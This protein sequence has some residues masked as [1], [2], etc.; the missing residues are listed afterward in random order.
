MTN[1]LSNL[2]QK[3]GASGMGELASLR[4]AGAGA[5]ELANLQN[6]GA[7]GGE[8]ANLQQTTPNAMNSLTALQQQYSA[9]ADELSRIKQS[10][11][12]AQ[13]PSQQ[14]PNALNRLMQQYGV[15]T[16]GVAPYSGQTM[17]DPATLKTPELKPVDIGD[18]TAKEPVIPTAPVAPTM[19]EVKM[20][21]E[22]PTTPPTVTLNLGTQ[23]Y[24]GRQDENDWRYSYVNWDEY[25]VPVTANITSNGRYLWYDGKM[26]PSQAYGTTNTNL[27]A[28]YAE[29]WRAQVAE[30]D[31]VYAD[32]QAQAQKAYD[33][34]MALYTPQ[35]SEFNANKDAYVQQ[36]ADYEQRLAEYNAAY[37]KAQEDSQA[38]YEQQQAEY[39]KQKALYEQQQAHPEM[40]Y[41]DQAAY[42]AYKQDFANRI[43]NTDMYTQTPQWGTQIAPPS[44]AR[45][46][47]V[48]SMAK[49][50]GVRG[51]AE[52]DIVEIDGEDY[53]PVV[54]P[55][56][57]A[58]LVPY[59]DMAALRNRY[60][61][62]N[63]ALNDMITKYIDNPS[64][65]KRDDSEMYFRLASAFLSPTKTKQGFMENLGMA[66]KEMA[67]Y[68]GAKR[69]TEQEQ[70]KMRLEAQKL[71]RDMTKDEMELEYKMRKAAGSGLV[72][73]L[74]GTAY[75][76]E[77][78]KNAR[79]RYAEYR[80]V[81]SVTGERGGDVRVE[82]FLPGRA[83]Y[84]PPA[85]RYASTPQAP[86]TIA[87][88]TGVNMPSAPVP[89]GAGTPSGASTSGPG[90]MPPKVSV[91]EQTAYVQATAKA[92]AERETAEKALRT[93]MQR[94]LNIAGVDPETGKDEIETLIRASTSGGAQNL[95]TQGERFFGKTNAG[96]KAIQALTSRL[97]RITYQLVGNKLDRGITDTD[98][99]FLKEINGN[100][101]D[102]NFTAEERL[103]AWKDALNYI[104]QIVRNDPNRH[105]ASGKPLYPGEGKTPAPREGK[106]PAPREGKI[107]AS[108]L[109][110]RNSKG[111]ELRH[112]PVNN[113]WA[114]VGPNDEIEEVQ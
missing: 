95:I 66:G 19:P 10:G 20:S 54:P 102:P 110:R 84:D 15:S 108:N 65:G 87:D 94:I 18:F 5:S 83:L 71:R 14:G 89:P 50:Y 93:N 37:K 86:R 28:P 12:V 33:D 34:A 36:A 52:G 104:E 85:P 26:L 41:A 113:A 16:P 111:W 32:S 57:S 44:Y 38:L 58:P 47:K 7:L 17:I 9:P 91:A 6:S 29:Q 48:K 46:G 4:Q 42:D 82:D 74:T 96:A 22:R 1:E 27:L 43:A 64:S 99:V 80:E 112:D 3:Y 55:V 21:I 81:N 53:A 30:W 106:T 103:F 56:E 11:A 68:S 78:W 67:E 88:A 24:P 61:V 51:Y 98:I 90:D 101:A 72:N 63:A 70:M 23:K 109:P 40:V 62:E 59:A 76:S 13:A 2:R 35:M 77:D 100:I 79:L 75:T 45:G 105:G 25:Q 92:K 8:L 107:P 49:K 73:P 39:A 60:Q 69:A 97:N 114:Y 31:K